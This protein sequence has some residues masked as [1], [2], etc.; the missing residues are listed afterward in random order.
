M[1]V[2]ALI[3]CYNNI[4]NKNYKSG[5]ALNSYYTISHL[6]TIIF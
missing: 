6:P 5:Y 3:G 1:S 2:V 4:I